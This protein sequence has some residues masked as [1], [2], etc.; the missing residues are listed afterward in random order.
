M[1]KRPPIIDE[2]RDMLSS[3]VADLTVPKPVGAYLFGST[4]NED[5]VR[6]QP[7]RGDLD[8]VVVLD[9][10]GVAPGDRVEQ[11]NI[12]R[13]AKAELELRLFQKLRREKGAQQIVSLVPVTPF[14]VD[15][16]VH[17]D[18]VKHIMTG[19]RAY[20]LLA[21][22]E[23][24]N[25]AGGTAAEPLSDLHRSVLSFVQKKRAEALAISPNGSGGLK[26]EPHDDPVPKQLQRNFAVA[27][28]DPGR[29]AD[30]SDLARGL[31][32][33][34]R[35]AEEAAGWTP[36]TSAFASWLEVRLG[37]RGE[38]EPI[39]TNDHFL[40]VLE[41]I[42]DR[43]REQY[44]AA[45]TVRYVPVKGAPTMATPSLSASHRL[46]ARFVVTANDKLAGSKDDLL[47]AIRAARANMKARVSD[48]FQLHFEESVEAAALIDAADA[49]L[50]TRE[51][52]RK[53]KAFERRTIVAA[54]QS[55]WER[56]VELILRYGGT[57]FRADEDVVEEACRIAIANW[58]A[59][60]A[61]NVV[62][63]GGIFEAAHCDLYRS[64]GLALSFP[65]SA[66][67]ANM[68][69]GLKP[70]STLGP[71]VLAAGFVPNLV[72]KYIHLTTQTERIGLRDAVDDAFDAWRWEYGLK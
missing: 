36:M 30:P 29:D 58:F 35:F 27:T 19:A 39:I 11:S 14:E 53:V 2:L 69:S 56:G 65:A 18:D 59:V 12:L 7:D 33:I 50:N 45:A 41:T 20:D 63:P 28:F 71:K 48:P 6:F 72:S 26:I 54:R 31:R 25:L 64:D 42:F 21:R 40:L 67:T 8:L 49:D 47:R 17:K 46:D 37:A 15:Q 10:E 34:S 43:V 9:W 68:F 5:G 24:D 57:L 55:R 62:N 44:P 66:A 70:L 61:T 51:H 38:V 52:R 22:E 32:E 4:V 13:D 23:I 60:A 3:W 16:A 1:L